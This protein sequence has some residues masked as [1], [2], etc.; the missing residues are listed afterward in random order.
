MTTSVRSALPTRAS[1]LICSPW[2][3]A[4]TASVTRSRTIW[5]KVSPGILSRA[6]SP[7]PVE[8]VAAVA[9]ALSASERRATMGNRLRSGGRGGG[10]GAKRV[11]GPHDHGLG[12]AAPVEVG[13]LGAMRLAPVPHLAQA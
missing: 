4:S 7:G 1:L 10:S 3:P 12:Y 2:R 11:D 6:S 5:P 8:R 9:Y 13:I